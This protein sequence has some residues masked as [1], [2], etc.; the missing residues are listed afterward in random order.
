MQWKSVPSIYINIFRTSL[1]ADA[2]SLAPTIPKIGKAG[3]GRSGR[4]QL[5]VAN[6]T[7][8][9]IS[10]VLFLFTLKT[11]KYLF[12]DTY[13]VFKKIVLG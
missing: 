4:L 11:D 12:T 3:S 10:S 5:A 8:A 9:D 13:R 2:I 6:Q 7:S 1:R